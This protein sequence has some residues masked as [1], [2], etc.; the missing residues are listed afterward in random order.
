MPE[1][2]LFTV[3]K[4]TKTY[5]HAVDDH[6][7]PDLLHEPTIQRGEF[8]REYQVH[9]VHSTLTLATH[10][11][12]TECAR[13]IRRFGGKVLMD[14]RAIDRTVYYLTVSGDGCARLEMRVQVAWLEGG[15]EG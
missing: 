7:D 15:E 9:G 14:G 13:W 5:R 6:R 8:R 1:T 3:I 11:A 4:T 2:P 10:A 12:A